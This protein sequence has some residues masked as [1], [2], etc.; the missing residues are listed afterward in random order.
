[1]LI[2]ASYVS[3]ARL[4]SVIV[5]VDVSLAFFSVRFLLCNVPRLASLRTGAG[6]VLFSSVFPFLCVFP[7][8]G[9]YF[10]DLIAVRTLLNLHVGPYCRW[11]C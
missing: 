6:F 7:F 9:H 10:Y 1:M 2:A 3:S 11:L 4:L 8:L 5:P